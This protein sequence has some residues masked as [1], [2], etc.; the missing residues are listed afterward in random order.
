[1]RFR[2]ID[3]S[4][5]W[6]IR[7]LSVELRDLINLSEKGAAQTVAPGRQ[8][9]RSAGIIAE[10]RAGGND[11]LGES[12]ATL[13]LVARLRPK[14]RLTSFSRNPELYSLRQERNVYSTRLLN[15]YKLL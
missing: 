6:T 2:V 3:A 4:D 13:R 8:F 14:V 7:H 9:G 11:D 12:V 1:M 10:I 5:I 15:R